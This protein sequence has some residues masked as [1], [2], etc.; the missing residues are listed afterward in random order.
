M[1]S[2]YV[3]LCPLKCLGEADKIKLF[4]KKSGSLLEVRD[5]VSAAFNNHKSTNNRHESL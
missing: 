3:N 4:F 5:K 1:W 2:F